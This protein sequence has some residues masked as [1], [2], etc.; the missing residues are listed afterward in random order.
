MDLTYVIFVLTCIRLVP[1]D[2]DFWCN[3]PK[4]EE[5]DDCL[6]FESKHCRI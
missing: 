6:G 3:F 4:S 1:V 2:L 5:I